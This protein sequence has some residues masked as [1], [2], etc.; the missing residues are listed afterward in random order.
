MTT[1]FGI[2]YN[3]GIVMAADTKLTIGSKKEI[4]ERK[5]F[6]GRDGYFAFS[7]AGI[8]KEPIIF[9]RDRLRKAEPR[10]VLKSLSSG[11]LDRIQHANAKNC[12]DSESQNFDI[13]RQVNFIFATRYKAI[14]NLFIPLPQLYRVY[15]AGR[16]YLR[17]WDGIG[18]GRDLALT[19]INQRLKNKEKNQRNLSIVLRTALEALENAVSHDSGSE[20]YNMAIITSEKIIS[21]YEFFQEKFRFNLEAIS[22]QIKAKI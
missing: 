6:F 16:A 5:I 19:T 2:E 15:P 3:H 8:L 11:I 4:N 10:K 17:I 1:A 21:F 18:S 7:Y 12:V 14:E 9:C 20:G 22:E 13:T